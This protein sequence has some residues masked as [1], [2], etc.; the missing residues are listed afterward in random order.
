MLLQPDTKK[1]AVIA[2][3]TLAHALRMMIETDLIVLPV[4]DESQHI[5]GSL[6]LS[7]VLNLALAKS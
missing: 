6:T 1:A 3:D 2:N 7:E 4:I 5:I